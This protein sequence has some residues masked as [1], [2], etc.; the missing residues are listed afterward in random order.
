VA[1]NGG[2][3]LNVHV[4][5]NSG[6]GYSNSSIYNVQIDIV[7]KDSYYFQSTGLNLYVNFVTPIEEGDE[8]SFNVSAGTSSG[9]S[10]ADVQNVSAGAS[11]AQLI[12]AQ[13]VSAYG[14][15]YEAGNPPP[16]PPPWDG[17][18]GDPAIFH[19]ASAPGDLNGDGAV[20]DADAVAW[21]NVLDAAAENQV[22]PLIVTTE[23]DA[24]DGDYSFHDLSLR[25]AIALAETVA[26]PGA[27][28]IVFAKWV[29][30]IALDNNGLD[31]GDDVSIVGPGLDKLTVDAQS[32]TEVFSIESGVTA[33]LRGITI[34]GGLAE[35]IY[36]AGGVTANNATVTLDRVR[37]TGNYSVFYSA[38]ISAIGGS[39]TL[40]NST[41]DGNYGDYHGGV[42]ASGALTVRGSTISGN[43][44]V[45]GAGG[46][47][48]SGSQALLIANSTI[49]GNSGNL[50]GGLSITGSGTHAIVNS[51]ITNN[52]S[53]YSGGLAASGSSAVVT[54]HNT[55]I[56]E[57]RLTD[58]SPNDILLSSL[59]SFH[60]NSAHNLIGFDPNDY[61]PDG[62]DNIIGNSSPIDPL[63]APLADN[64]GPTWTHLLLEGSDAIDGGDDD[65]AEDYELAFDQRGLGRLLLDHVDI[66]AVEMAFA[67]IGT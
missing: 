51:T 43:V 66:G 24:D 5:G 55:I 46:I 10:Y 56:A 2:G 21:S 7:G 64:G 58:D 1:I 67:E 29:E 54:V 45:D 37:V 41:V 20:D 12:V 4:S 42:S 27:D 18:D 48:F 6:T 11:S 40:L 23:E 34:S 30:S 9:S 14:F 38:G 15:A 19:Y 50:A 26:Y 8:V 49:S 32:A 65:L 57:N 35:A 3:Y 22:S 47:A 16:L 33:T 52:V 61:F 63:L 31:V 17:N 62:N 59:A 60:A 13:L 25:E 44:G 39:L 53:S 28:T 36:R